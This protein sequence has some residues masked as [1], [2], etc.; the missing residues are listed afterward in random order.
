MVPVCLDFGCWVEE[1][2]RVCSA[3]NDS[4]RWIGVRIWEQRKGTGI[5]N[6][7]TLRKISNRSNP[8]SLSIV[9]VHDPSYS[10]YFPNSTYFIKSACSF[11]ACIP[12][13]YRIRIEVYHDMQSHMQCASP[14][15]KSQD[16]IP[17]A[18][19]TRKKKHSYPTYF[20][21]IFPFWTLALAS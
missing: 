2:G 14:L 1:M 20:G 8:F 5:S 13:S 7:E 17:H 15:K 3:G 11:I 16:I 9:H 4:E 18:I 21:I 12:P 6:L 10:L 19:L